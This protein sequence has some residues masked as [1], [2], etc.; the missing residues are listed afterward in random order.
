MSFQD[1]YIH[2]ASLLP[3]NYLPLLDDKGQF[4]SVAQETVNDLSEVL[5][6]SYP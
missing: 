5:W 1:L 2:Q 4:L 3:F 6:T